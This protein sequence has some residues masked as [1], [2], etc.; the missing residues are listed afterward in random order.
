MDHTT[1][2]GT[3]LHAY[4]TPG[5]HSFVEEQLLS[6]LQA[7]FGVLSLATEIC[8]NVEVQEDNNNQE[9]TEEQWEILTWL[10]AETFQRDQ[11]HRSESFLKK[12]LSSQSSPQD[13]L[14]LEV[15]PRLTFTTAW[16]TNA[17]T[18]CHNC[19]LNQISRIEKST[20]YLLQTQR[21]KPLTPQ[22]INQFLDMVHDRMTECVYTQHLTSF[23]V[24]MKPQPVYTI[25]L[26]EQGREALIKIN[27]ELGLAFDPQDMDLYL[28]LFV[29]Y[30]KRNPTNVEL[31][32]LAQSNSEHSRHWFFRGRLIV[33]GQEA[34]HSLMKV[35]QQTLDENTNSVIAF[36]DNSSAIQG[37]KVKT[38]L[39]SSDIGQDGSSIEGP[40]PTR[41]LWEQDL[42]YDVTFTAKHTTFL[43]PWHHDQEPKLVPEEGSVMDML[44]AEDRW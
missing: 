42:T 7:L 20:L 2:K 9:L 36:C 29:N 30:L 15:G 23:K 31:F 43:L 22:Q 21:E 44:Q 18:I 5:L 25:P 40:G 8:Y 13:W 3:I 33:D 24:N 10:L 14:L 41:L 28:D 26:L 37:H 35:V 39:P 38:I 1:R 4:R 17:V 11:F 6:K 16:S 19:G 27:N 34:P 32:D 12:K